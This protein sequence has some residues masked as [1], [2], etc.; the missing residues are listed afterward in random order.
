M[1]EDVILRALT[2]EERLL[3]EAAEYDAGLDSV[4]PGC[5][6]RPSPLTVAPAPLGSPAAGALIAALGTF[7]YLDAAPL[8]RNED[9][10]HLRTWWHR[11]DE[12]ETREEEARQ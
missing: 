11:Q 7:E 5:Q 2:A 1:L 4:S 12:Y 3:T 9:P 10:Q 8:G 6:A